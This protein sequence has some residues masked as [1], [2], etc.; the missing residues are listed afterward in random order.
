MICMTSPNKY[1]NN[2]AMHNGSETSVW[3]IVSVIS[4]EMKPIYWLLFTAD[5]QYCYEVA[6]EIGYIIATIFMW[7][8]IEE[9]CEIQ[10]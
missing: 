8:F 9:Y 6:E 3:L 1:S 4:I 7:C 2:V 10:K 5:Q